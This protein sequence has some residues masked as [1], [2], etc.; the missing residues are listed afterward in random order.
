MKHIL[1][2][3]AAATNFC[4]AAMAATRPHYGGTLRMEMQG[5]LSGFDLP[6]EAKADNALLRNTVQNAVCNRLVELDSNAAPRPSLAL[7]W[8]SERDGRSWHF[9]LRE[10]VLM[11]SGTPLTQ[12]MVITA[13]TAANPDWHVRAEGREVLI[14]SDSPIL[15]VLYRLA[16]SRNSICLAGDNGQWIGSG[17]FQISDYLPGQHIELRS[18]DD[19]WQGR[20]FLDRIR[21]EMGRTLADQA[22]ELSLGKTDVIEADPTQQR[23]FNSTTQPIQLFALVF[24]R[25]RPAGFDPKIRE[26]IVRSIDRSSIF[27]VLLRRQ[28]EQSAALLPEWVSG[29]AHLFSTAQDLAGAQQM[30]APATSPTQLSLVY[31]GNDPL[32]KLIAERVA[33]NAREAG[34]VIQTRPESPA[35]RSFDADAKLARVRIASPD[36]A[37][38]LIELADIF[39][40]PMLRKA[41]SAGPIDVLYNLES[42]ALKDRS[43][44]T[45]A[46]LPEAFKLSPAVHDWK[47]S[48]WGE[49]DLGNLWIEVPR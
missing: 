2:L 15:D 48:A 10:G 5:T 16:E 46:Y 7:S 45:L 29:Y 21:I 23:A 34:I 11:Q 31:D 20:P 1:L 33:V 9:T 4:P 43:V 30:R 40:V 49:I 27:S 44:I 6:V 8:R 24:T 39:D 22:I 36:R 19:A 42:D 35:F 3:L 26:A 18:F 47:V 25:N 32:A 14:Q 38:A 12:Q 13:L 37:V 28:G 41:E 17:P